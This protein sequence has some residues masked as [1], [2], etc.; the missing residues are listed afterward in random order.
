MIFFV[1]LGWTLAVL[2]LG[3]AIYTVLAAISVRR[4]APRSEPAASPPPALTV[5]KPLH[6]AELH[7][8]ELGEK[9]AIRQVIRRE[10]EIQRHA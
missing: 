4:Y 7:L 3:G 2:A 6:G 10:I 8:E 1:V 5:L 9:T